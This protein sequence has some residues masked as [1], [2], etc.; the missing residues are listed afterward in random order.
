MTGLGTLA[1][2]VNVELWGPFPTREAIRCEGTPFWTGTFA[3]NGDGTYTTAPRHARR[4]GYYTYRESIAATEA[5]DAV[6]DRAA[7]RRP[8]RRCRG[9][10]R[11]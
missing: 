10:R 11:R 1:A 8:R 5:H 9:Q 2:T 6:H 4:A 7:A 3:A